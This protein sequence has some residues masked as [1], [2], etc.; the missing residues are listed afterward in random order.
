MEQSKTRRNEANRAETT[1]T[2]YK[3]IHYFSKRLAET[4]QKNYFQEHY[5]SHA[6]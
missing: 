5:D 3:T 2:E 6:T 4:S 1:N